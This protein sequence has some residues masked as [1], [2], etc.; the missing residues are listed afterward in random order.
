MHTKS[1]ALIKS[2]AMRCSN[3][4]LTVEGSSALLAEAV[5]LAADEA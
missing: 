2:A 1:D 4:S 3:L 5:E